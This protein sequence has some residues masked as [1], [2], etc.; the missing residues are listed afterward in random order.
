[1]FKQLNYEDAYSEFCRLIQNNQ[2]T[3]T[4]LLQVHIRP[5]AQ[6]IHYRKL[7]LGVQ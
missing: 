4:S 2:D 5:D 6:A 1:M 3:F 7:L